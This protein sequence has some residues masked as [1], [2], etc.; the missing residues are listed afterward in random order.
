MSHTSWITANPGHTNRNLGTEP[1]PLKYDELR[2]FTEIH[3][4]LVFIVNCTEIT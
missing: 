2:K 1:H 3:M 4:L